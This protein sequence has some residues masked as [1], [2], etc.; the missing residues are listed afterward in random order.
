MCAAP[1]AP[2]PFLR[3]KCLTPL[4]LV[5]STHTTTHHPPAM[6]TDKVKIYGARVRVDSM[7]KVGA[8]AAL[9]CAVGLLCHAV[10]RCCGL[11]K[12]S[13]HGGRPC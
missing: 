12:A 13:R 4:P 5:L 3:S 10:L 1:P 2:P 11:P 6:D 7:A 8:R 9:R